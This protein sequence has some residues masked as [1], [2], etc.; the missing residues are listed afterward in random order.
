MLAGIAVLAHHTEV[1]GFAAGDELPQAG[2]VLI[3]PGEGL[4]EGVVAVEGMY[5]VTAYD[6]DTGGIATQRNHPHPVTLADKMVG[7]Q[8]AFLTGNPLMPGLLLRVHQFV[9]VEQ[10]LDA[11]PGGRAGVPL[12]GHR[13]IEL[14]L[15][16]PPT[17]RRIHQPAA[18]N[19]P[20]L[21]VTCLVMDTMGDIPRPHIEPGDLAVLE[22]GRPRLPGKLA[23]VMLQYPAVELIGDK[24]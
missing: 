15:Q 13:E 5:G 23:Q 17:P 10:T 24:R 7:G 20:G 4:L 11:K 21:A 1:E 8:I 9:D 2:L 6:T 12:R 16:Q 14:V 18:G 19:L 22:Q 3:E